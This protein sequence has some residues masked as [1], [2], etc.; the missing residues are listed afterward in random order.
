MALFPT[1]QGQQ[2]GNCSSREKNVFCELGSEALQI[3]DRS[4][5]I[6]KYKRGQAVFY[7][8]NFPA[9]L[10]CVS[11]GVVRL[12]SPSANGTNHI[13]RMVQAGGILGYRSLFAEGSY[14]ANAI[15][16]EDATICLIPKHGVEELFKQSPQVAL[17]FL[18]HISQELRV[19]EARYQGMTDKNASE[20]IAEALLFLKENFALQ[21]WTR[22]EI[23]EWASTSPETVMRT[24]A[25]F[26]EEKLVALKGRQIHILDRPALLKKAN[27]NA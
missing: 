13:L 16:H 20:R 19:A 9:G 27:L 23:A 1:S 5:I 7:A 14:Q 26:E 12:E 24:L 17:K 2:C 25:I 11:E 8:G 22:K 3:L 10:Y 4:K 18:N 15:V 21:T 6:N